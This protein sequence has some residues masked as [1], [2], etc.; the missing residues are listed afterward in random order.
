MLAKNFLWAAEN[1][2][3]VASF[4]D[5]QNIKKGQATALPWK[6]LDQAKKNLLDYGFSV[7]VGWWGG[8]GFAAFVPVFKKP[9]YSPDVKQKL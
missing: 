3:Y 1:K 5:P 7:A 6:I 9:S 2:T 8:L 4:D